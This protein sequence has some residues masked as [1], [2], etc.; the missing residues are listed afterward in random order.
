MLASYHA[1]FTQGIPHPICATK[2][3]THGP[4]LQEVRPGDIVVDDCG[5]ICTGYLL[6]FSPAELLPAPALDRAAQTGPGRILLTSRA[7]AALDADPPDGWTDISAAL[8][9][10]FETPALSLSELPR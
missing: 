8:Q 1:G 7:I 9:P 10:I 6:L 3:V 2:P 5:Y 4:L